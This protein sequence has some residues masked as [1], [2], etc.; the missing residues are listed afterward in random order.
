MK[1]LI[2]KV[3]SR[4][5]ESISRKSP[6]AK[7]MTSSTDSIYQGVSSKMQKQPPETAT[8][9]ATRKGVLRNFAK[10]AGKHLCQSLLF[11]KVAG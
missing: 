7:F 9:K 8:R 1:R 5:L 11:K 10:F 4:T 3:R 2:F 6:A